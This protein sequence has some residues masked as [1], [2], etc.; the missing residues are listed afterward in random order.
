[1]GG[2]TAWTE[3]DSGASL[4]RSA[5]RVWVETILLCVIFVLFARTFV[6]QQSEIPSGSMEDTV[7]V[8]DLVLVNRFLYAPTSFAWERALLPIRE[9]RRGDVV[10]FEHPDRP[11]Q[12][13][14]KRVAGLPG[15]TVEISGGRLWVQ[16][17][18]LDEPYLN[19]LYRP[20][21]DYGPLQVPSES[22]FMLGD[23]RNRS[24]D[25]RAWGTVPR[26]RIKGRAVLVL[27]SSHSGTVPDDDPLRIGLRSLARKLANM[28]LRPRWDRALRPVR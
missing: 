12:D 19:P 17:R 23:H 11:E 5:A 15:E 9:P 6:G 14:I 1:M 7:L 18:A 25:S 27:I 20:R 10:V 13:Y 3:H 2:R 4:E 16:G 24:S 8:G 26:A 21:E 22:Y 28:L